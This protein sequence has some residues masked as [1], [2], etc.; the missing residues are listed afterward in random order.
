[1]QNTSKLID[2]Q[3]QMNQMIKWYTEVIMT[4]PASVHLH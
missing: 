4:E 3:S 2:V 1:M